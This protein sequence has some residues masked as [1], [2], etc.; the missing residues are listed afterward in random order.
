MMQPFP[1][2]ARRRNC[3]WPAQ[4]PPTCLDFV[5]L[6]VGVVPGHHSMCK[7]LTPFEVKDEQPCTELHVVPFSYSRQF[8]HRS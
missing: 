5:E 1:H 8:S 3:G 2:A 4:T 7:F 6:R